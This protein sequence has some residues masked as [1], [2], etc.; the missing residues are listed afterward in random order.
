MAVK[1]TNIPSATLIPVLVENTFTTFDDS[2]VS[3]GYHVYKD[4]QIPIIDN[5]SLT[6]EQEEHNEN[7]NNAVAITW[8]F[9][10]MQEL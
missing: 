10:E 8:D 5:D 4:V 1:E 2:L 6:C 3:G 9:M 7:D